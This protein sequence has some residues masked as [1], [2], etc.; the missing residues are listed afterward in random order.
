MS[1]CRRSIAHRRLLFCVA[2]FYY[3]LSFLFELLIRSF[4]KATKQSAA[5][6]FFPSSSCAFLCMYR[7]EWNANLTYY[8][9]A[10]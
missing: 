4:E 9:G 10:N 5:A 8:D 7:K 1:V 6:H 3:F 2:H